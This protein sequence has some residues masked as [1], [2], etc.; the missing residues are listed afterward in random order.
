MTMA[1]VSE[2]GKEELAVDKEMTKVSQSK[3]TEKQNLDMERGTE[4]DVEMAEA[5]V[6]LRSEPEVGAIV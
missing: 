3:G 2:G 6:T 1:D 4:V 5:K